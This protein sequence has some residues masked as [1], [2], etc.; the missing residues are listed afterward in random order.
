MSLYIINTIKNELFVIFVTLEIV[1]Y[2]A[3]L[4][5]N[6]LVRF[7]ISGEVHLQVRYKHSVT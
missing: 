5:V 6:L 2:L 3:I 4:C 1:V 7:K